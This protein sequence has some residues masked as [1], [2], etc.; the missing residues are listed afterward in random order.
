M[1]ARIFIDG[2]VGTTGLQIKQRLEGRSDIEL[3]SLP[4]ELR[5]DP[6][7][8][9]QALNSADL[10][11]LCLPDDAAR[12]AV[13][14]IDNPDVRVVDASSAHR[15]ADGWTYGF[16]EFEPDQRAAIASS[17]RVSNPGCYAITA[18]AMLHP[19]VKQE[20]LPSDWPVTLN[21]ISGYSGGGRKLIER[22]EDAQAPDHTE[23]AYFVYGLSLKHKHL[24]EITQWGGLARP[25]VFVPS[26]GRYMQG[27]IVQ[28]PLAL[29]ALPAKPPPSL[30]HSVLRDHYA[31]NRFVQVP[32]MVDIEGMTEL[33]PEAVN[34]TNELR[35]HVFADSAGDQAVIMGL[36]DN[37]S[38]GASG[39]AVQNLNIM[40]GLPEEAGLV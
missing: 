20:L 36:I 34:G 29:W 27:M 17:K 35:L 32:P 6:A 3:V 18:V 21:A 38:K 9:S 7:A 15:A 13:A 40:L 22:F 14:M 4:F 1:T 37:L 23:S 28:L 39:Q 19:L 10:V 26:V 25:P 2:E 11:V 5:K 16:P 30:V 12:E 8:R 24:P 33:D 31:G